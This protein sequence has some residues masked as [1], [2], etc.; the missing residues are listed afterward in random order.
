MFELNYSYKE[1][2]FIHFYP[3]IPLQFGLILRFIAL[4]NVI[5]T[6]IKAYC[7]LF[8]SLSETIRESYLN[9]FLRLYTM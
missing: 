9:G 4:K 2:D 3:F 1:C 8:I 7:I 5:E 6:K